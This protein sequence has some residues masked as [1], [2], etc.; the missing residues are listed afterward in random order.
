[1]TDTPIIDSET[2]ET[3]IIGHSVADTSADE[4]NTE[5]DGPDHE[6]IDAVAAE[7]HLDLVT[8]L[9]AECPPIYLPPQ[10]RHRPKS[11]PASDVSGGQVKHGRA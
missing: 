1:M 11:G 9:M 7:V 2:E 4:P 10:G 3:I 5:P 8:D 6:L